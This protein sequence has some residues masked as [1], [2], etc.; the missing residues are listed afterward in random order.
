MT[1][2]KFEMNKKIK[3][4]LV[5][6]FLAITSACLFGCGENLNGHIEL[7]GEVKEEYEYNGKYINFP[8][9]TF[10][11]DEGQLLSYDVKYNIFSIKENKIVFESE[12]SSF[13][14]GIGDYKILYKHNKDTLSYPF[15]VIDTTTPIISF[16]NIPST[17]FLQEIS[18]LNRIK[19]PTYSVSDLSEIDN[20]EERLYFNN[21]EISI[22]TTLGTYSVNSFGSLRYV[23]KVID[24][25]G[26]ASENECSWKIK[27]NEYQ[28][29]DIKDGY[30]MDFDENGYSNFLRPSTA[31]QYYYTDSFNDSYLDSYTDELGVNE[32]GVLKINI[33]FQ[34]NP[35]TGNNNAILF[36]LPKQS[37]FTYQDIKD[38]YL[39][40][41]ILIN[42]DDTTNSDIY[43]FVKILGNISESDQSGVKCLEIGKRV[44]INKWETVYIKGET[45]AKL[46]LFPN[47]THEWSTFYDDKTYYNT[48]SDEKCETIQLAFSDNS[49]KVG[50]K[51]NVYISGIAIADGVLDVPEVTVNETN[52][53]ASWPVVTGATSYDIEING[54]IINITDNSFD[55]SS[56]SNGGYIKVKAV[57]DDGR[58]IYLD[59]D[60]SLAFFGL[61]NNALADMDND[62]YLEMI[63]DNLSFNHTNEFENCFYSSKRIMSRID[64]N[65]LNINLSSS[66]WGIVNGFS[67]MLPKT[68]KAFEQGILRITMML[69]NGGLNKLQL[70]DKKGPG[71]S[72]PIASVDISRLANQL[73]D[74]NIDMSTVDRDVNILDF[75]LGIGSFGNSLNVTIKKIKFI[76]A[77]DAPNVT[78]SD[79]VFSWDKVAH[80]DSYI[81]KIN[82]VVV[83]QI[84]ETSYRYDGKGIF[85]VYAISNDDYFDSAVVSFAYD[86]SINAWK[87]AAYIDSS[88]LSLRYST[89]TLIQI[90]GINLSLSAEYGEIYTFDISH[91]YTKL[92]KTNGETVNGV[93]PELHYHTNVFPNVFQPQGINIEVGEIL[94]ILSSSYLKFEDYYF[95]FGDDISIIKRQKD[96]KTFLDLY[97][98]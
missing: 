18:N 89:E 60:S 31:N 77:L 10:V 2:V 4:F 30:L 11:D 72:S 88:N 37:H 28:P 71:K 98:E 5:L 75:I 81:I 73:F 61:N 27:D 87:S 95:V 84:N 83:D 52:K 19:L 35:S 26:N 22:N 82:N 42:N 43:D 96:D 78:F 69:D 6:P 50:N 24:I 68:L 12:Y 59:S 74:I 9:A 90:N 13:K 76:G 92:T 55:L 7:D 20:I 38:K 54:K 97:H 1:G 91:M 56:F 44:K 21:E 32:N 79:N 34:H 23:V 65:G 33:G 40:I 39:A 16:S 3:N 58:L 94:T 57:K 45:A 17:L 80:A 47:S 64:E 48:I 66:P 85:S 29:T 51:M 62:Y 53:I 14:L 41:R 70:F 93:L 67:L 8:S 36:N 25:Y 46:G 86:E 15:K 63:N 49:S